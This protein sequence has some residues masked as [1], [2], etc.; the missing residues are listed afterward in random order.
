MFDKKKN[1]VLLLCILLVGS[2]IIWTY[3]PK[4]APQKKEIVIGMGIDLKGLEPVYGCPWGSPLRTIYETL[5]LEDVNLTIQPLLA[6]SGEVSEDGCAKQSVLVL[7][8]ESPI[9]KQ[10]LATSPILNSTFRE[11]TN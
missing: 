10:R 8:G 2:I 6:K 11:V 7:V 3:L 9:F 1:I 4:E 5:L